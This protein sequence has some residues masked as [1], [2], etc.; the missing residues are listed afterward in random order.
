MG[1]D[2]HDKIISYSIDDQKAVVVT[3]GT[4]LFATWT[5]RSDRASGQHHS[6]Y[7][8]SSS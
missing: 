2:A 1:S 6:T 5:T 4:L 3:A 7:L 8:G